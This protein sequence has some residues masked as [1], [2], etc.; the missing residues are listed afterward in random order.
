MYKK[1]IFKKARK[2]PAAAGIEERN[3]NGQ[4]LRSMTILQSSASAIFVTML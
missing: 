4:G 2:I 1:Y 3:G